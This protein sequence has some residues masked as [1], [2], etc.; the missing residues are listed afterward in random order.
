MQDVKSV[1]H[2]IRLVRDGSSRNLS[3]VIG[4]LQAQAESGNRLLIG[5]F[6]GVD[7]VSSSR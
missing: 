3:F 5:E 2:K 4:G 7:Y 1:K 6:Q